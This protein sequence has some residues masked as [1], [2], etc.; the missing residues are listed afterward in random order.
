MIASDTVFQDT[1]TL[2]KVLLTSGVLGRARPGHIVRDI[3]AL[4]GVAKPQDLHRQKIYLPLLKGSNTIQAP[5]TRNSAA[6][7]YQVSLKLGL[8]KPATRAFRSL[9]PK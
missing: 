9:T 1:T 8:V 3:P 7:Q 6:G 5:I 4:S 2:K